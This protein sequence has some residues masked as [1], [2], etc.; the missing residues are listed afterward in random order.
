MTHPTNLSIVL[1]QQTKKPEINRAFYCYKDGYFCVSTMTNGASAAPVVASFCQ[2]GALRGARDFAGSVAGALIFAVLLVST[3]CIS[4]VLCAAGFAFADLA[5]GFLVAFAFAGF[6]AFGSAMVVAGLV[7]TIS[8]LPSIA[9]GFGAVF[10][11]GAFS[12]FAFAG[13]FGALAAFSATGSEANTGAAAGAV[14]FGTKAAAF[15]SRLASRAP[16]RFLLRLRPPRRLR[17][18]RSGRGVLASSAWPSIGATIAAVSTFSTR[19]F[20]TG[21]FS[22]G[23]FSVG[24]SGRGVRSGRAC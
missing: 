16:S 11:L 12:V 2:L 19:T 23:R 24:L 15:A 14:S 7:A 5:A 1:S 6:S 18:V 8:I 10:A 9:I 21:R 20:S 17:P 4:P 22:A 13:A 3:I